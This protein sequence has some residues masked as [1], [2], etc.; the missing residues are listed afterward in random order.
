MLGARCLS[1]NVSNKVQH[2]N[3]DSHRKLVWRKGRRRVLR[4]DAQLRSLDISHGVEVT[5]EDYTFDNRDYACRTMAFADHV[6]NASPGVHD[7]R[8]RAISC[9]D[10]GEIRYEIVDDEVFEIADDD[11]DSLAVQSNKDERR[12]TDDEIGIFKFES[13]GE[14]I[15]KAVQV[16][17]DYRGQ[18]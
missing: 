9:S 8:E 16:E 2:L 11:N 7:V 18:C 3:D 15:G 14:E 10:V 13:D 4:P 5:D 1:T 6:V 17:C 12:S